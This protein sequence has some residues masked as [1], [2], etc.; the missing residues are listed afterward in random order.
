MFSAILAGV[1]VLSIF[2]LLRRDRLP[3]MHSLWWLS[4]AGLIGLLGLFPRLIDRVAD[5]VGVAYSPSLLFMVAILVLLIKVLLEDVDVSQDRRR[6]LRLA[7]KVA[8]LEEQIEQ[9]NH[10]D[11]G[12]RSRDPRNS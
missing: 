12:K 7:Q 10:E 3:V 8:M 4:V 9:L 11:P 6:L 5:W 2:W 1:V